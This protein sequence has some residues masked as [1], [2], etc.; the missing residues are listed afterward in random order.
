MEKN[1][2]ILVDTLKNLPDYTPEDKLWVA[3]SSSLNKK[4]ASSKLAQLNSIDPP[5]SIWEN[6]D[7][8]LTKREKAS[9]LRQFEPPATV[10][11]N[12][13]HTLSSRQKSKAR[14]R[15][16]KMV[17]WSSAAAAI[18][19]LGFFILTTNNT[20]NQ[21]FNYTEEI[22]Q[23]NDFQD[24]NDEEQ[25]IAQTLD[26]ICSE[27]PLACSSPEFKTMEEDLAFLN[28]SKEAIL[29]QMSKYSTNTELEI[30]LTEI[31]L[32]RTSLIKEMI[33]KTM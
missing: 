16:I 6:I 25:L 10:W 31:E 18:L 32:E 9:V 13:D 17:V 27:K 21:N 22:I 8:A 14:K 23:I 15:I 33:A 28:Q 5:D 29:Q 7:K 12:I 2:E 20:N 26:L 19:I 3:I 1:R 4:S 24:W 30:M 11:E